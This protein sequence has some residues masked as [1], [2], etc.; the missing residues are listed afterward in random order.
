MR[1]YSVTA[2]PDFFGLNG[3]MRESD[4][5]KGGTGVKNENMIEIIRR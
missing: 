4:K 3:K 2:T 5:G 1:V